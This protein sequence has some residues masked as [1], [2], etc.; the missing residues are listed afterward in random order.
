MRHAVITGAADGIGKAL[1]RELI[2][3]GYAISGIDID[4]E[5]AAATTAELRALGGT[6]EFTLADLSYPSALE[7]LLERLRY[8]PPIDLLIH[9][10]GI[11]AVGP[12]QRVALRD[13]Q[14]VL[15]LNLEAPLHLTSALLRMRQLAP[16]GSLVFMASLSHFTSY[17]GAS[18]YAASKDGLAAYARGL[19]A[20]LR[21]QNLHVLT[22]FPGPTRTAHARRYSPDNRREHRR[23]APEVLAQRIVAAIAR[24]Q[25]ILLPSPSARL[26]ALFGRLAPRL[27]EQ[28]MRRAML[29]EEH[30]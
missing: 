16:G 19:R 8:A 2:G 13:Q 4:A 20:A 6:I 26:F 25:A 17:P 21:P 7:Q 15:D 27:S 12:F 14:A 1:A 24:R 3:A 22:V 28:V 11:S 18:V 5:R 23:M 10:A 30:A 9:N 29:R